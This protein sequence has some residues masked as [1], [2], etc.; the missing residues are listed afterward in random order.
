M[1][2]IKFYEVF[3]EEKA[4]LKKFLPRRI[5]SAFTHH[6]IQES[7]DKFPPAKLIC[8]RTQSQI[9][10]KWLSKIDGILSRSQGYDHLTAAAEQ[11]RI[12]C[13][14]LGCYC[15]KAVADHAV[16]TMH[17]LLRK[18][19]QQMWQ[20]HSFNREDLTGAEVSG[21]KISVI[22]VGNIGKEIV[23]SVKRLNVK[24]KG[25]D[26]VK[27]MKTLDYVSLQ[28]GLRWADVIFCTLPLTEKTRGLLNYKMIKRSGRG[29]YLINVSRGE[30]TPSADLIRMLNEKSLSGL[31]LDAYE[32]EAEIAEYLRHPKKKV[33][34]NV[35]D[36]L[37]LKDRDNVIFTPHNAFNTQEALEEK[38]RL[39]ACEAVKFLKHGRFTWKV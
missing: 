19:K 23:K 36:I 12:S 25:V 17:M 1:L 2:D 22:G 9:P 31:S 34:K 21:K 7:G 5:K 33:S 27:R 3:E 20:F 16:L 11:H 35:R 37:D 6:T 39:T 13:G 29:K 26:I 38:C 10:S 15:A 30:I 24:A 8:I 32:H 18:M 14:H 28:Q 4:R